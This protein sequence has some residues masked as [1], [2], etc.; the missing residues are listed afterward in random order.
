M[1]TR[2]Q[3][4]LAGMLLG[5]LA[6]PLIKMLRRLDPDRVSDAGGR[7]MRALGPWLPEHRVGRANLTAAFPEKSP[8]EIEQILRGVWENLGRVGGEFAHIDRLWDLDPDQA[9]RGRVEA[10]REVIDR[11]LALRDD[12]KPA[13]VFTAHLAN[14]EL[15]ALAS[16][17]Y[18]MESAVLFRR[19]NIAQVARMVNELRSVSMGTL[20]PTGLDAP[21]RVAHALERGAH[22]G[23]LVDQYFNRGVEVTFF[24]RRTLAN[25][26]LARVA[27]QVDCPIHGVRIIRLPD[28]R[29]RIELTEAI[30]PV[31]DREG[32]VDVAGTT[33]AI[34]SIIEGWIREYPDQWLWLHRRWR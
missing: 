12:G 21:I 14:W 30:A 22:V 23:M 34:T 25:P 20:I 8:A 5:R 7:F 29:F 13:L 2:P 15:P 6:V 16:A 26:F 32:R 19:P 3:G 28:H 18:D 9:E 33:Q 17:T 24:G 1:A 11:F 10:T 27:R 4:S 31:R